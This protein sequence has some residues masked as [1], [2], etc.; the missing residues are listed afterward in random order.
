M[1]AH[2]LRVFFHRGL[3]DTRIAALRAIEDGSQR[4]LAVD[5][6][7]MLSGKSHDIIGPHAPVFTRH[8]ML[9][10]KI[11]GVLRHTHHFKNTTHL[12]FAPLP[13]RRRRAQG[14]H[15]LAGFMAQF[16]L[17][18]VRHRYGLHQSFIGT[19]SHDPEFFELSI[20]LAQGFLDG[21]DHLVDSGGLFVEGRGGGDLAL[22]QAAFGQM[23]KAFMTLTQDFGGNRAELVAPLGF[24]TLTRAQD[25]PNAAAADDHAEK[26]SENG[27][28]HAIPDEL[29]VSRVIYSRFMIL[30]RFFLQIAAG[31]KEIL[32]GHIVEM[33]NADLPFDVFAQKRLADAVY[34]RGIVDQSLKLDFFIPV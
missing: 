3:F 16:L 17:G 5:N 29:Q 11:G 2:L 19:V 32:S 12:I 31:G 9:R 33:V 25:K 8:M 22:F 30:L 24:R 26:K 7:A 23:Q 21:F 15:E 10:R 20:H 1:I 6:D 34:F 4:N 27:R 14:L 13:A 28:V 18:L